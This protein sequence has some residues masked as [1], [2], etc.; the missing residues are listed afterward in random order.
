MW[1]LILGLPLFFVALG[2]LLNQRNAPYLMSG[3]RAMSPEEQAN[4]P[5][6]E[7]VRFFR[8][9]HWIMGSLSLLVALVFVAIDQPKFATEAVVVLPLFAYAFFV[10]R[11]LQ[12]GPVSQR[13][14]AWV[15]ISLLFLTAVGI[16]LLFWQGEKPNHLHLH[17]QAL[18]ITGMYGLY[19]ERSEIDSIGLATKLPLIRIKVNGYAANGMK[20][21]DF[22][23]KDSQ[24][25]R[26]FIHDKSA[27]SLYLRLKSGRQI[28]YQSEQDSLLPLY[29]K[30]KNWENP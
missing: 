15:A 11:M 12:F 18:E 13:P 9:F 8:R 21:G 2:F 20:K 10:Y 19:I 6:A 27:P 25:I 22:R 26:L 3:Y 16:L 24:T 14:L 4:Y 30:L 5:L 7:S 29:E 23:T 1:W 28:F 17:D